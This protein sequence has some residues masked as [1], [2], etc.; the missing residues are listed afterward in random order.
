MVIN[1]GGRTKV[2]RVLRGRTG[3]GRRWEVPFQ[4]GLGLARR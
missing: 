3:G 2:M 1:G 4:A